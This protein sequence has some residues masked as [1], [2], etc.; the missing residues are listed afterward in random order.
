MYFMR[1]MKVQEF[2]SPYAHVDYSKEKESPIE[3]MKMVTSRVYH[4]IF[5]QA[6]APTAYKPNQKKAVERLLR[7]IQ[8]NA[9]CPIRFEDTTE[10]DSDLIFLTHQG[11]RNS[12]LGIGGIETLLARYFLPEH[13][14]M[15]L[16]SDLLAA[17]IWNIKKYILA[18]AM[19][20]N[21]PLPCDT[22]NTDDLTFREKRERAASLKTERERIAAEIFD[23]IEGGT[24]VI[25]CPEG[26]RSETG[27]I[28]P[29]VS[30]FFMRTVTNY[31]LP[32]LQSNRPIRIGLLLADT[33]QT[34][35]QGI[36]SRAT[37]FQHTLTMQ[38]QS[39]DPSQLI[40]RIKTMGDDAEKH[41]TYL[42]RYLLTDIRQIFKENLDTLLAHP[43]HETFE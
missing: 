26:T 11:P 30:T 40:E 25:L 1:Y 17:P 36:G 29:F 33:L 37:M 38:L 41:A 28:L 13:A 6:F 8:D 20:N 22:P 24:P 27:E 39:Y 43:L 4:E 42:G 18:R 7:T 5:L 12:Q 31:I 10:G 9:L 15:V 14:R 32:R 23:V 35:P 21:N 16:R 19:K 34:F 2:Y 3:H